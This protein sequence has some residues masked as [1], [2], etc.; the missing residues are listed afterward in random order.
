MNRT[1]FVTGGGTGIGKGIA[2]WLAKQGYDVAIS[3]CASADGAYETVKEIEKIGRKC[4]AIQADIRYVDEIAKMFSEFR[5]HFTR[6]DL[7]VNNAGL[8]KKASFLE[9]D[10]S[11]FDSV[12]EVNYR[13]AFFCMQGA[14]KM[15]IEQG[16][17]GCIVVISSNNDTAYFADVAVYGSVKCAVTKL[18]KHVAIELAKYKI[19]VNVIAP[20]WTDTGAE[21]L[22]DKE[23]TYY[24]IPL[25]KWVMVDEIAKTVEFLAS[26][27]AASITGTSIVIDNGALL[28]SDVREKYGF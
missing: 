27:G 26:D 12:C 1:A 20:G 16:I 19:N 28:M 18:A 2:I 10:Q 3:Y 5:R 25:Q 6:M 8:T 24:K 4:L 9:T 22:E 23:A 17:E 21:R 13:G 14:A 11:L 15:M 7:F